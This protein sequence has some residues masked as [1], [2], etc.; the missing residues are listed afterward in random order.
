MTAMSLF[1]VTYIE[2]SAT[3][4]CIICA[5]QI[6]LDDATAGSLYATGDQAFACTAHMRERPRWITAWAV[7]EALQQPTPQHSAM[8]SSAR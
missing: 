1:E 2:S 6:P 5:L 4:P 8:E 3:V 7:F